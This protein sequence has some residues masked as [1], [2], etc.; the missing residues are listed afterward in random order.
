[1]LNVP[2]QHINHISLL[3]PPLTLLL[4]KQKKKKRLH[5]KSI[6][7]ALDYLQN[8]ANNIVFH[9]CIFQPIMFLMAKKNLLILKMIPSIPLAYTD[10]ANGGEKKL[11]ANNYMN[12]LFYASA[13]SLACMAIT[14]LKPS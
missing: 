13:E 7:T 12:I 5:S 3:I 6:A 1:M 11:C 2:L 8:Y 14:L 10:K 4:T 9:F